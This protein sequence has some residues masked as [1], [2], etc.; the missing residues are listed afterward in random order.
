VAVFALSGALA[1]LVVGVLGVQLLRHAAQD[2]ALSNAKAETRLAGRFATPSLTAGVIAERPRSLD[3]LDRLI[4]RSVLGGPVER[5][6]IWT[7]SGRIVYSDEPRLIGARFR[8]GDEE[9]RAL[10][11]GGTDAEISDLTQPENR[12]ERHG[13]KLLEVYLG[14]Q[15]TNGDHLLF[16]T[17]Q[18]YASVAASSRRVWGDFAPALIGAIV[19]LGLL[20]I[21]FAASLVRRLERGRRDREALLR[22]AVEASDRERTRIAQELHDGAVQSLSG[23][24]FSLAAAAERPGADPAE[25]ERLRAGAGQA[26]DAVRELRSLLV[27]IYPPSL[28]R[29][30]LRGALEDVLGPLDARG[31]ATSLVLPEPLELTAEAETVLFRGAQEAARNVLKHAGASRLDV[32]L[33]RENG[34]VLLRARDDGRGFVPE[35][36]RKEGHLGLALLDD[37]VRD[38]GGAFE[39]RSAPGEGTELRVEVPSA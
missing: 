26:R 5:V 27:D 6:K 14:V 28:R 30:G 18:R 10:R 22:R 23:L 16:E 38:A 12:Y 37:L 29:E 3:A 31:V 36:A 25:R 8:L 24:A 20:Q 15:G 39:V 9:R 32:V 21:P 19:L 35:T 7:A 13:H 4:R 34:H 33:S 17:Y 1:V 2:E 11:T